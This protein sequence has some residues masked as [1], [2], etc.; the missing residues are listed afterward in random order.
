M[1]QISLA[2]NSNGADAIVQNYYG[3]SIS[4]NT[5]S[6]QGSTKTDSYGRLQFFF[7]FGK[8]NYKPISVKN[9]RRNAN[10]DLWHGSIW[11]SLITRTAN[12]RRTLKIFTLSQD[13]KLLALWPKS[14]QIGVAYPNEVRALHLTSIGL[15]SSGRPKTSGRQS[16]GGVKYHLPRS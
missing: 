12:F 3:I 2:R 14:V 6:Q 13:Y 5:M 11:I 4:K 9:Q 7:V 16:R 10:P 15:P 1:V 8:Y